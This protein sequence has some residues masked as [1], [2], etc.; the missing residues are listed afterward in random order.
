MAGFR[1]ING[2]G[3]SPEEQDA[4]NSIVNLPDDAVP[5]AMGGKLEAST[6]TE[7]PVSKRFMFSETPVTPIEA[8]N[9]SEAY[10]LASTG[11]DVSV[12]DQPTGAVR[13]I[14]TNDMALV[15]DPGIVVNRVDTGLFILQPIDADELTDPIDTPIVVPAIAPTLGLGPPETGQTVLYVDLKLTPASVKTNITITIKLGGV[16]F[17]QSMF[18]TVALYEAPNIYRFNYSPIWDVLVGDTIEV[19]TSSTDGPMI[20]L[21][22]ADTEQK[23]QRTNFILWD[24]KKVITEGD[25]V[26]LLV[27]DAGYLDTPLTDAQIK[28]QYENNANTNAFTDAEQSKLGSLTGGRYLGVFADLTALQAAYPVGLDGDSATVTSPNANLFYWDGAAWADSGT[29][30]IGD[31]LKV[32]YDPLAKNSDAFDMGN[33]DESASN[34]ILT[35]AERTL[36]NDIEDRIDNTNGFGMYLDSATEASPQ[37]FPNGSFQQLVN[38]KTVVTESLPA[39]VTEFFNST[40]NLFTPDQSL[41]LYGFNISFQ[42]GAGTR[43]KVVQINIYSP[44]AVSPGVDLI[45]E[46]RTNR[47]AKTDATENFISLYFAYAVTSAVVTNGVRV[48]LMFDGTTADVHDVVF[49]LDKL[50]APLLP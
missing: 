48:D 46:R 13:R 49:Q 15:E 24:D 45:L 29:G 18:P 5:K 30:Y 14:H 47:L 17:A 35:Q 23:W 9:I 31:M 2:G 22:R 26:S 19:T 43:D 7:D 28:T 4:V 41:G 8:L 42:A 38:D 50:N 34:K 1:P 11:A 25:N 16:V 20:F 21:G 32:T 33:M 12:I 6:T 39:T 40:S 44:D 37:T 3:L 27:N 36:L 10:S